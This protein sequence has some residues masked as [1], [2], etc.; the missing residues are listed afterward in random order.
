MS[1]QTT[2][3]PAESMTDPG[4]RR[5][6]G[7]IGD[8]AA[9]LGC[10]LLVGAVCGLLWWL[11]VDPA[12]FTKVD[13]RGSMGELEL[14]KRFNADGWYV[15]IGV[16]A[17]LVSGVVLTAWRSRDFLLTT[18]VLVIGAALAAAVMAWTGH[19]LGPGDTD[20]ALAAASA[21]EQVPV[22]LRVTAKASYL[23]WPLAAL[24]G[25]LVVLWSPP[26]DRLD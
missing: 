25:A 6:G 8:V 10:Y 2:S 23:V 22:Q 16:L 12:V 1:E 26:K 15:V 4:S 11:A 17:G 21:G 7:P 14:G 13:G 24:V 9:V 18:G 3:M 5:N 19:L 20:A